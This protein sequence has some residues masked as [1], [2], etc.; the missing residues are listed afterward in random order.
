MSKISLDYPFLHHLDDKTALVDSPFHRQMEAKWGKFID[1]HPSDP[2]PVYCGY[3]VCCGRKDDDYP[4]AVKPVLAYVNA[5]WAR[6]MNLFRR[7][8]ALVSEHFVAAGK[9]AADAFAMDPVTTSSYLAGKTF[10]GTVLI[11]STKHTVGY[12]LA[13]DGKGTLI[14]YEILWLDKF[15]SICAV[16]VPELQFISRAIL[17]DDN[18]EMNPT[19]LFLLGDRPHHTMSEGIVETVKNFLLFC[20]FAEITD[21]FVA[22]PGSRQAREQASSGDSYVNDTRYNVRRL[23][24]AYFKNICRDDEFPV[25]GH[26]RLQPYGVGRT[27]RRLIYADSFMKHGY[28]LR[29]GKLTMGVF[30]QGFMTDR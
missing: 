25:K 14:N 13:Y 24:V 29:A 17:F 6:M 26:F 12:C 8:V 3:V 10:S 19:P 22:R 11:A 30:D 23:S 16:I 9:D 5:N 7:H 2:S 20:H 18:N 27:Q 15:G 4:G 28:H 1:D 21:D